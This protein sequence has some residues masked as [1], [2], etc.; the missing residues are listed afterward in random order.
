MSIKKNESL[1]ITWEGIRKTGSCS[2]E[3]TSCAAEVNGY[4][5]TATLN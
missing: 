5:Q 3:R 1:M 2:K 4:N